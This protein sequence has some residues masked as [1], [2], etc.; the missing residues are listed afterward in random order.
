MGLKV[1]VTV[2]APMPPAKKRKIWKMPPGPAIMSTFRRRTGP[3]LRKTDNLEYD[4][5][6]K[7]LENRG[8]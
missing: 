8:E 4:A 6:K 5:I 1:Q 2:F 7:R 3:L